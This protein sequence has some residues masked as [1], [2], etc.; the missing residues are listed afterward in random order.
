MR[1][2][3]E[4]ACGWVGRLLRGRR[5]DR[6]PLRRP[7]DRAETAILAGL[8]IALLAGGP[9]AALASG[10]FAHNLALATQ[11]RQRATERKVTVVTVE[12]APR[13]QQSRLAY[14]GV[15]ARWTAPNGKQVVDVIPVLAGTPIGT[16]E[17][18]WTTFN[19]Q[20]A[21]PPLLDSQ[22]DDL[23][24]LGQATSVVALVVT[25]T[26]GWAGVRRGLDRRRFAAWDADWQAI[27]RRGTQRT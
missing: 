22:V 15:L 24:T 16:R 19:G 5:F 6:N 9:F 10:D 2:K 13:P 27:D 17:P 4:P 26:L 3:H 12:V 21:A 14:T 8:L 11:Q 18:A 7:S 25:L 20:L 1:K 23:T